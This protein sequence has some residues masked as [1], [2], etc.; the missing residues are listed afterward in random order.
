MKKYLII[1]ISLS[2]LFS[3]SKKEPEPR[4]GELVVDV[5]YNKY[6]YPVGYVDRSDEGARVL[7]F[8][9]INIH[10]SS[11]KFDGTG[12]FLGNGEA[13]SPDYEGI[14]NKVGQASFQLPFGLYAIVVLSKGL[15]DKYKILSTNF[16]SEYR[17]EKIK[18]ESF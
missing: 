6:T 14:C 10:T 2:A 18:I 17:I 15:E 7:I 13:K 12:K 9:G 3:C 1:M 16:E 5:T 8:K 11:L 4:V